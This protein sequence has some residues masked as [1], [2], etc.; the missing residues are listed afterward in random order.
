MPAES[1]RK[2]KHLEV[3]E[4]FRDA[5]LRASRIPT[6]PPAPSSSTRS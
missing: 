4:H 6:C 2:P 5:I 3:R 1:T